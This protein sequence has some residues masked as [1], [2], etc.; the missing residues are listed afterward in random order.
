[1]CTNS[2]YRNWS[3]HEVKGGFPTKMQWV[4]KIVYNKNKKKEMSA[5]IKWQNSQNCM[6]FNRSMHKQ[7]QQKEKW[8]N[9]NTYFHLWFG[10][11]R[12]NSFH[13]V[14]KQ[15]LTV[16]SLICFIHKQRDLFLPSSPPSIS[17]Y[18]WEDWCGLVENWVGFCEASCWN[19]GH[20]YSTEGT[21]ELSGPYLALSKQGLFWTVTEYK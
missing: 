11:K 7:K 17:W 8:G 19:G 13:S 1:M 2:T 10:D 5:I 15:Y 4:R 16:N 6:G 9:I 3:R 12:R 18:L 14:L 20:G 21:A